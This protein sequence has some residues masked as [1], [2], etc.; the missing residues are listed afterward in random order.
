MSESLNSNHPS[1]IHSP[2]RMNITSKNEK[3]WRSQQGFFAYQAIN[4]N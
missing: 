2:A 4:R 1:A 3:R